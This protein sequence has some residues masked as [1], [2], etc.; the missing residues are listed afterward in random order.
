MSELFRVFLKCIII[1]SLEKLVIFFPF[2]FNLFNFDV[3]HEFH[4]FNENFNNLEN[5]RIIRKCEF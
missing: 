5:K 1:N 4:T 2:F 3:G